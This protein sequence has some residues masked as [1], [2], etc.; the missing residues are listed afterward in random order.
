MAMKHAHTNTSRRPVVFDV[1]SLAY[2]R[3]LFLSQARSMA[4]TARTA[5]DEMRRV[6]CWRWTK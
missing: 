2:C 4:R 6:K 1:F 3:E 5:R